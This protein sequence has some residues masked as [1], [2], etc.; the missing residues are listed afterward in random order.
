VSWV[1]NF[2]ATGYVWTLYTDEAK[3]QRFMSLAFDANGHL[4]HIDLNSGHM[5]ARMPA[6][7]HEDGE[8][9]SNEYVILK[10]SVD[11]NGEEHIVPA[12]P[13]TLV[14]ATG[15]GDSMIAGFL[16]MVDKGE[17]YAEALLYASACGT[18]TALTS[19]MARRERID[20]TVARLKEFMASQPQA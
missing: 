20:E 8:E 15:A 12:L 9:E 7:Y 19:G 6:L 3:T 4:T 18:A 17:S 11:E 5:P 2:S 10:C 16:A 1:Q 13:I 14:N